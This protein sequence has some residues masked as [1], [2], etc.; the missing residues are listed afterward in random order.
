MPAQL[1]D[2]GLA[3]SIL[4]SEMSVRMGVPESAA[5]SPKRFSW[6]ACKPKHPYQF[7]LS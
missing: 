3:A 2:L 1:S 7:N 6:C 4:Y 5:T